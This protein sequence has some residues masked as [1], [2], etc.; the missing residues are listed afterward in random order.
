[1]AFKRVKE[2]TRVLSGT[3]TS[4]PSTYN[5]IQLFDGLFTTGYR[6]VDFQ[7][8]PHS[9]TVAA[10]S[11]AKLATEAVG[12]GDHWHWE[13][14]RELAW[15]GWFSNKFVD[16]TFDIRPDNMVIEDLFLYLYDG[17]GDDKTFNY[18]ITLEKYT[19]P[20]WDGAGILVENLS[21]AGPE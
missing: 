2:G 15:A 12:S 14:V 4:S 19:F 6:I 3:I 9:P 17:E 21:Q 7:I 5:R 16:R 1:M 10:Q 11:M 20:A 8:T 18:M 13:D